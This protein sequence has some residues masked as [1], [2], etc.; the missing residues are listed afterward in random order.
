M[1]PLY[2]KRAKGIA[3][4]VKDYLSRPI[5]YNGK[6]AGVI[7]AKQARNLVHYFLEVST[8][9]ETR[10]S[11]RGGKTAAEM[12]FDPG[13]DLAPTNSLLY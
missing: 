7:T 2:I 4:M 9:D 8:L 6:E 3:K 13:A 5:R 10:R 1:R 12:D 11:R